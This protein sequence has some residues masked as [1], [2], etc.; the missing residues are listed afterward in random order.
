MLFRGRDENGIWYEG[1]LS[2]TKVRYGSVSPGFYISNAAG[3]PFAYAVQEE[4]V[5]EFSGLYDRFDKKIF[6]GHV[7]TVDSP[8][9]R[10]LVEFRR[11]SYGY[12]T[13]NKAFIPFVNNFSLE[14]ND[15]G[16]SLRV[17]VIGNRFDDP[18]LVPEWAFP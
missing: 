13:K 16:R 10:E 9:H 7:I 6:G 2:I 4:T 8:G 17:T 11:G 1:F 14:W 18:Q 12:F 3:R 15:R 5:S